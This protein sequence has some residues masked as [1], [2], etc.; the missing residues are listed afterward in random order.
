MVVSLR[1]SVAAPVLATF[2]RE[3]GAPLDARYIEADE[4]IPAEFD[5]LW[6]DDPRAP[7]ELAAVDR[8]APLPA[9]AL[10]GRPSGLFDPN[11]YWV[12]ITADVRVIGYDPLRVDSTEVPT[13]FEEL[14]DPRWASHVVLADPLT[15]S[16]GWHAATL[17]ASK[18]SQPTSAFYR[19][20]RKA[21][22]V[23][24][25]SERKV[26]EGLTGGGPPIGVLDGE[27]AFAAR[28][29]G[30]SIGILIPD[31]DGSGAVLRAT[32]V[33]LGKRAATS[34]RAG[35]LIEY[36]L[37]P[38]VGRRLALMSSHVALLDDEAPTTGVVPLRD[39]KRALP[40][41]TEVAR[42]LSEVRRSL[43]DLR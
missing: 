19:D 43:Q 13:H 16:A 7:V 6:S 25:A 21:G 1:R 31:Q 23:F 38:A 18:G 11:G 5:V 8:L 37:S 10:R 12:G 32:T 35:A 29:L 34:S 42:Q 27:V 17:F 22:A 4:A 40:S 2:V 26:L 33:A 24:V 39:L 28:E 14:L 15:R 9:A 36:L 20:L 30:Q 41:Q 3:T